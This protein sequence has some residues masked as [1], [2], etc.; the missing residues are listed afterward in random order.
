MS[1]NRKSIKAHVLQ[2]GGTGI[3]SYGRLV[4]I[5]A[6][7]GSDTAK[8]GRWT[9]VR[10]QGKNNT[11]LRSVSVYRPCASV[12]ENTVNQQQ[13][14]YF[15]SKN[16]DRDP[17][18]IFLEDFEQELQTWLQKGENIIVGGDLN[19]DVTSPLIRSLFER[20][21]MVN[22]MEERHDLT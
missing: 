19:E 3:M 4:H 12:G 14:E 6:G 16:D 21:G 13:H 22:V 8:L 1:H 20:Q 9:W 11:I 18:A 10:Y 5:G 17:R 2:A 7:A 15:Q